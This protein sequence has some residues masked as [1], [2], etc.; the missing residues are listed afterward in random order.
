MLSSELN[1]V[2]FSDI[3][4]LRGNNGYKKN[5]FIQKIQRGQAAK[6]CFDRL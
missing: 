2:Y 3:I 5:I 1:V 4:K 6:V